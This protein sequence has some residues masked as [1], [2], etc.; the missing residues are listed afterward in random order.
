MIDHCLSALAAA[1]VI[2][3]VATTGLCAA[4]AV[5]S[6]WDAIAFQQAL[7]DVATA[8]AAY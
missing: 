4:L 7:L 8:E 3:F 5:Q 6:A 1:W 2:T